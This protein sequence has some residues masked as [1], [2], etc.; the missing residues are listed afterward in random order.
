[1]RNND[2]TQKDLEV[3]LGISQ[4]WLSR[5]IRGEFSRITDRV[6]YVC[7][8]AGI[9]LDNEKEIDEESLKEIWLGIDE[10]WD[11]SRKHAKEIRKLMGLLARLRS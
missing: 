8:Y 1:M 7:E 6:R 2:V 10:L 11:G 3:S 4:P 5:I 9:P